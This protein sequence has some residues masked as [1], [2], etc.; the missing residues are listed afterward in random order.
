MHQAWPPHVRARDEGGGGWAGGRFRNSQHPVPTQPWL[1]AVPG[2][3][4]AYMSLSVLA[5]A[6]PTR[7]GHTH[8]QLGLEV[9]VTDCAFF[10]GTAKP[11]IR[12]V[13]RIP[14]PGGPSLAEHPDRYL[15]R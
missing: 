13:T 12:A 14:V 11:S 5:P 2:P 10:R 7:H 9:Q 8:T 15:V 1:R 3:M 4:L 6:G